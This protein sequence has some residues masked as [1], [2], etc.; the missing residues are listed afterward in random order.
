MISRLTVALVATL[1]VWSLVSVPTAG[2]TPDG[3]PWN[4]YGLLAGCPEEPAKFHTCAL[5]KAKTFNP[6]RTADG[7]P[8]FS[9]MWYRARVTSHNI[10]EHLASFGDP[11]G[12]SL[13]VD[14]AD[15]KIPYKPWAALQHKKNPESY[16]DP[17]ALCFVPGVGRLGYV[18]GGYQIVQTPGFVTFFYD[19]SHAYRIIPTDGRP[20]VGTAIKLGSGDSVGHWEGNTLVADVANLNG[21]TWLDDNGNFFS[22]A[23]H[24]VERWTM[25]AADAIHLEVRIDDPKTYTKPWTLAFGIKRNKAR[26]YELMESACHEG[27]RNVDV[28]RSLC[29]KPYLGIVQPE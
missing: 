8:D 12:V 11:G 4:A 6:P 17:Q 26:G 25:I 9:G 19:F 15:G 16:I 28:M 7:T 10:E 22:D 23:A 24:A 29:L 20:H 14:P 27:D 18:P 5:E 3:K 13:I 2:Q 21:K 1:C